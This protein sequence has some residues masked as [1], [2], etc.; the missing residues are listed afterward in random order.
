MRARQAPILQR[1]GEW[2]IGHPGLVF[3]AVVAVVMRA[4]GPEQQPPL[5]ADLDAAGGKAASVADALSLDLE[6][7]SLEPALMNS[8]W[9]AWQ[10]LVF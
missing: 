6:R 9:S 1:F 4:V 5:L 10:R 8:A 7:F 2:Q 3:R